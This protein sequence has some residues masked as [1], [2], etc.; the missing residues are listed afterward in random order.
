M[1]PLTAY[2]EGCY[3]DV[4]VMSKWRTEQQGMTLLFFERPKMTGLTS[5]GWTVC[6]GWGSKK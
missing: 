6:T 5:S 1:S 2:I 3:H 4:C